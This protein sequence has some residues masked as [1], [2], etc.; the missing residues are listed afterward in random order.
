MSGARQAAPAAARCAHCG[1]PVPPAMHRAGD[2]QQFCCEGCR[3]VYGILHDWGFDGYYQLLDRQGGRGVPAQV[4]GRR[5]D[6]LDDETLL[7]PHAVTTPRGTRQ[8][9]LYLEGVHCA[10][11]VWLVEALPRAVDGL[12]AVRLNLATAVAEIEWDPAQV[13]LSSVARA[14]DALGYAPHLR[15]RRDVERL[16]RGEDRALLI[17]IGVAAV[18]AM[19]LMFI[20]GA[21]Y[22][23]EHQGMEP[24]FAGFFRLVSLL[25]A[26]PVVLFSAQPFFRAAWV[27]LRQRVPHMDLPIAIALLAAF[28]YSAV[29]TVTGAGPVYFDSLAALVGLL[30]GA[31]Y[32]Q[33]RAQ[34]AAL[35]RAENLRGVAFVEFA[36][37]LGADGLALEVPLAA[38]ATGE[39]VEVRAGELIPVDGAVIA[40]GSSVDNAV[41]TGESVPQP[42]AIGDRVHAGAT[43]LGGRLVVEVQAT[44][45]ATR[46]GALLRLVDEAMSRRA[47]IVQ[48]ADRLSRGFVLAVLGLAVLAGALAWARGHG[49]PGLAL[50]QVVALLVVTC[51]CALG[52]ATPVALTVGLARAARAG[53]FVKNPDAIERLPRVD[54]LLLD[55]TGTLTEGR[56]QVA[57]WHGEPRVRALASALEA[58]SIHPIAQA[59]RRADAGTLHLAHSVDEVQELAGQ[60]LR[61]RVDGQAVAVGNQA[62]LQRLAVQPDAAQ[63]AQAQRVLDEGLSPLFV[64]VDGVVAGVAGLGDVLRADALATLQALRARGLRPRILSGDHPDV[65]QRVAR[66]LG[67]PAADALGGLSPEDKRDLVAAEVAARLNAGARGGGVMMVGDG[68]NDAAA[69]ALADVGVAVQGGSGASVVAAD[70]VLTRPGL[71]PLLELHRG[72]RGVLAVVHRNLGFSLV[73]NVVGASLALLGLVGPLLAAVLMPISSLTVI[74]S[75]VLQRSFGRDPARRAAG[76]V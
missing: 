27:G 17:K 76:E 55:K 57:A 65:V 7:A 42:V 39:R 35:E 75:S 56:V 37:R 22:A 44:G 64:V 49:D 1:L 20:H 18:C 46:V 71:Q 30:L 24:R 48:L 6:E 33:Q 2:A 51:P 19:N 43:N 50:Q 8:V 40:G 32:L 13:Q 5:F 31:R 61:G 72:S 54:T 25:L 52:L 74:G 12:L 38:L 28:G 36:R 9:R 29:T 70:V 23:G 73:Y 59:F 47:P 53:I 69:L 15:Q 4:K 58:H 11:C 3:Q 45:D 14:L 10:A 63:A 26:L 41:L 67:L 62:L 60:G 34:R 68:V 21:L 66:T 16:R